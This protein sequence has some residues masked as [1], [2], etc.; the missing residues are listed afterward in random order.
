MIVDPSV[1]EA[2]LRHMFLASVERTGDP[3]VSGA[4][5]LDA[6]AIFW[7]VSDVSQPFCT[8]GAWRVSVIESRNYS[9]RSGLMMMKMMMMLTAG[10]NQSIKM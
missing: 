3:S 5:G 6:V 2:V 10:R 7:C 9:F 4:P 1:S 8:V